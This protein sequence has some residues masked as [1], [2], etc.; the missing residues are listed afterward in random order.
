MKVRIS[1]NTERTEIRL[2]L[3]SQSPFARFVRLFKHWKQSGAPPPSAH[4]LFWYT[5]HN[6]QPRTPGLL[7]G[8]FIV[9]DDF[10]EYLPDDF[11]IKDSIRESTP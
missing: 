3:S 8:V 9:R 11:L 6:S 7:K 1:S 10:D 5:R 2:T 4:D